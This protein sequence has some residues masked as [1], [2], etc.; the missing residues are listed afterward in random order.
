MAITTV[1]YGLTKPDKNDYYDIDVQNGNLDLIDAALKVTVTE[2]TELKNFL[3][4]MPING[5]D[6]T[7]GNDPTGAAVDGGIF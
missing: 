2:L 4:F 7:D 6:F 1:N 5:G 3:E